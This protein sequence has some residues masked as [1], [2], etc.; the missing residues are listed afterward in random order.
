LEQAIQASH[1]SGDVDL[2]QVDA[3]AFSLARGE[4]WVGHF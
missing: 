4:P 2:A 3:L 1:L